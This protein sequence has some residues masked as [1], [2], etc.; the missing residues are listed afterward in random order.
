M[1]KPWD[2]PEYRSA[3]WHYMT[4]GNLAELDIEE[5]RVLSKATAGAGA[6]LVPTAFYDQIINILR[7]TGPINQLANTITT[8]SARRSRSRRSRRTASR[9]G[10]QRTPPTPPPT[11]RSARSR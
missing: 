5:Q 8:D 11:R 4:V 3:Y 1:T 6:N 7:F 2:T 9:R 10:R